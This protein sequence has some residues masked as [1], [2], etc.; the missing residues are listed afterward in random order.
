MQAYSTKQNTL[1]DSTL[2]NIA[3]TKKTESNFVIELREVHKSYPSPAG[4]VQALKNINLQVQLGE[5]IAVVGKSGAGKSTLVNIITGIDQ[6]DHGEV[7]INGASLHLMNEDQRAR[8]RGINMGVVFQFFQLLPSINL[9]RNVS[10]P[11]EF[12]SLYTFHERKERALQL[13]RQVGIEEH[14]NKKPAAISGGQQQRLAI[15]RALAN[16]PPILIA[17]E[18]TG[19]LDS[20]TATE[21]MDLF[22]SLVEGGKTLLMV[23]HDREL[24]K[25]AHRN[26]EISD[27]EIH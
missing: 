26:I 2:T 25:N 17:D 16:D 15:A 10:I 7:L 22:T 24:A 20:R 6:P 5:F 4:P 1:N 8:L 3:L 12:C 13:L 18:P 21:I 14:A 19:N 23:T 9:I 11:M 27:G